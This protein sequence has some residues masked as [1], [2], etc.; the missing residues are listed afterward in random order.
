M[1]ETI[2]LIL[3][4]DFA[5]SHGASLE[6]GSAGLSGAEADLLILAV[7]GA[8]DSEPAA[9]ARVAAQ[10][11]CPVL[12]LADSRPAAPLD[13]GV[14]NADLLAKPFNPYELK[15][16]VARL[17]AQATAHP[18][19]PPAVVP[20]SAADLSRLEYPYVPQSVATLVKKFA[21]APFPL[22]I[23]GE[24]GCGQERVAR[25]VHRLNS[26]SGT[27]LFIH[28]PEI[29]KSYL[30][31]RFGER[32]AAETAAAARLTLFLYGVERMSLAAQSSLID[33]L[34]ESDAEGRTLQVISS[35]RADLLESVYRGTFIEPLY[36]RLAALVLR[37]QPL[38][39]RQADI[40]ALAAALAGD[41]GARLGLSHAAFSP[42]AVD[43][44]RNYLWFGNLD[45]MEAVVARSF[46]TH[47]KD[48]L[49]APDLIFE[50]TSEHAPGASAEA[51]RE[52]P[53]AETETPSPA[54]QQNGGA[55]PAART[56]NGEPPDLRLFMTELA[57]E[58]KNPMV[59]IK[60]FSQ[61]LGDRFDDAAFRSR[62]QETVTNDVQRMDDLLEALLEFA[63]F[64]QPAKERIYL[65]EQLS[66]IH[67]E[68]LPESVKDEKSVEWSKRGRTM[69]VLADKAH[70]LFAFKNL[71]LAILA[72]AKSKNS[73]QIKVE[74]GGAVVISY[75]REAAGISSL[76]RYLGL[77]A[78]Q[79]G[80]E[81]LP[82]RVLLAKILLERN[83][84]G[85][86]VTYPDGET[87]QMRAELPTL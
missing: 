25:A 79:G 46:A 7:G 20:A 10:F 35:A 16:R 85:L 71:F 44:L 14:K 73:I 17:L 9:L 4:R 67:D 18:A 26:E 24:A 55:V 59:T 78:A 51:R 22:L 23:L 32:P 6:S 83:G 36:Y 87:V 56:A 57:H 30:R 19:K 68:L 3:G 81:A 53:L 70:F 40:A 37:L 50:F 58:L 52:T 42:A 2:G 80:E 47:R 61:L 33:F 48:L 41:C 86:R 63:R 1:R 69:A 65:Y 76:T 77:T 62:F 38:R 15:E 8:A 75:L 82:L 13:P 27:P 29:A 34:N 39:E 84:G 21:A 66:R 60:T 31:A 5:V 45:E 12:F 64:N 49:D 43:R 74:N 72:Q 28:A 54:T 11:S